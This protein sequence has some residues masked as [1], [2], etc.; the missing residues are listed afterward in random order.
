MNNLQ[1]LITELRN[2]LEVNKNSY[3]KMSQ[4]STGNSNND[5]LTDLNASLS[6]LDNFDVENIPKKIKPKGKIFVI[7][8]FNEPLLLSIVPIVSALVVGNE[9][10][11]KPSSKNYDLFT[12][13]WS[14]LI[15][16]LTLPMHIIR[17][18]I[19]QIE[20][21]VQKVNAVYFFGSYKNAKSVYLLC[22]KH[23]VEFFPEV[24]TADCKIY[25]RHV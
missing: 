8:S 24:E 7:L 2:R 19:E 11:V 4:A 17:I 9:V 13:I 14:D 21:C 23:F 15:E 5:A 16:T 6:F 25:I 1:I 10:Y 22:A 18:P 3:L 12:D 20:D